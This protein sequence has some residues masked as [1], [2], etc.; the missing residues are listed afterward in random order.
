MIAG[1]SDT[2]PT[3]FT[4]KCGTYRA[5][6]IS[7]TILNQRGGGYDARGSYRNGVKWTEAREAETRHGNEDVATPSNSFASSRLRANNPHHREGFA[8]SREGAKE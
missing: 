5:G 6:R 7:S 3:P 8:R 1:R 4:P 2:T